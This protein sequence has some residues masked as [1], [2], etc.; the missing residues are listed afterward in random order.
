MTMEHPLSLRPRR[1]AIS[2]F[3]AFWTVA[4][5]GSVAPDTSVGPGVA[6]AQEVEGWTAELEAESATS[7]PL[8]PVGFGTL[9]QDDITVLLQDGN[10]RIKVVPLA[11]WAIRLT[12]PDTY[13]RLNSYKVARG[14]EILDRASRAGERGWPLVLFVTYFSRAVE[15]SFEPNDLQIQTKGF[16][17]RPLDILPVTP[18]FTR[19]RLRQQDTQIALYLFPPEI[20][21]DLPTTV[22]YGGERS[23][24]WDGIRSI[25]D[26]ELAQAHSRAGAGTESDETAP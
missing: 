5:G 9:S 7:R 24:R 4:C 18:D 2:S 23:S 15:E 14:K 10:V 20:D 19:E 26:S 1:L 17:F 16:L 12:A 13:N 8:G 21:L 22:A 25:L 6:S 3:I 11:E